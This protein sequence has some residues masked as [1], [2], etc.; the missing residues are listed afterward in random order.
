LARL[1][2]VA[3]NRAGRDGLVF[4]VRIDTA[5]S[6]FA[7]CGAAGALEEVSRSDEADMKRALREKLREIQGEHVA[8]GGSESSQVTE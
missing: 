7:V 3:K 5:R 6:T 4:P 1:L 8:G 2:W